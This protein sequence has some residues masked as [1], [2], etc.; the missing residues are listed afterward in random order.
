MKSKLELEWETFGVGLLAMGI[1]WLTGGP[2]WLI[3]PIGAVVFG[4][5]EIMVRVNEIAR[6]LRAVPTKRS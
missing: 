3:A 1:F 6:L 4:V 2:V 5:V